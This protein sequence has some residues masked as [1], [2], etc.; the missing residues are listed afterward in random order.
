[1]QYIS[2]FFSSWLLHSLNFALTSFK[3]GRRIVM[4]SAEEL[5]L[6]SFSL[7]LLNRI[8]STCLVSY[9]FL[10]SGFLI[11]FYL[12]NLTTQWT[13]IISSHSY[14]NGD[15]PTEKLN[16]LFNVIQIW[17]QNS[18]GIPKSKLWMFVLAWMSLGQNLDSKNWI[19]VLP[20]QTPVQIFS[21][22]EKLDPAF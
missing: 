2:I 16:I 14:A 7:L 3:G 5:H 10:F 21:K 22:M 12:L 9:I 8:A 1:M 18:A 6:L 17:W 11:N 15:W 19:I 4:L 13:A 20:L